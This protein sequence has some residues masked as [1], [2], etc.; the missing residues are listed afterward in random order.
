MNRTTKTAKPKIMPR[1]VKRSRHFG[2]LMHEERLVALCLCDTP[3]DLCTS[4]N[5]S[6]PHPPHQRNK[7]LARTSSYIPKVPCG[8]LPPSPLQAADHVP[9]AASAAL[10][11]PLAHSKNDKSTAHADAPATLSPGLGRAAKRRLVGRCLPKKSNA[12][13]A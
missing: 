3:L 2:A 7:H 8:D 1:T 13:P 10:L 5:S 12:K 4:F 11:V 9:L 6:P